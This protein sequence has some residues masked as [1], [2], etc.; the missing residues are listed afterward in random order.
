MQG[1][2]SSS[3]LLCYVGASVSSTVLSFILLITTPVFVFYAEHQLKTNHLQWA[4][5][6]TFSFYSHLIS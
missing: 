4:S 1:I 2:F 5:V 6:E 3:G